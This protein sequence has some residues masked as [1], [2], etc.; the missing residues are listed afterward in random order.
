MFRE[1]VVMAS[2]RQADFVSEPF[3]WLA[4]L[5]VN[6]FALFIQNKEPNMNHQDAFT[7]YQ[8]IPYE[9]LI[10]NHI[11]H[12]LREVERL[13]TSD[14]QAQLWFLSTT[15][16]PFRSDPDRSNEDRNASTLECRNKSISLLTRYRT[17]RFEQF[18]VRLLRLL[19][20]NFERKRHLQPLAYVYSDHPSSNHDKG[21]ATLPL[22]E[23]I[24]TNGFRSSLEHPET[25]LHNHAVMVVAPGLIET[26]V[27][28]APDLDHTFTSLDPA[29]KSL[30]AVQIEPAMLRDV[31][32][33]SSKFM[34]HA[35]SRLNDTDLYT[36][37]P[38]GKSEPTFCRQKWERDE[39]AV[40][41]ARERE[42]QKRAARSKQADHAT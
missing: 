28:V 1:R 4:S 27:A 34:K 6:A 29:N 10:E 14:K 24:F 13:S 5:T 17:V 40:A 38:K 39:I 18:Y 22:E 3:G 15:Y 25:A 30:H 8:N 9:I 41:M 7:R 31:M 19:I 36:V 42:L 37:L 11:K 20:K 35:S 32:F 12:L 2:Q 21:Y 26:L 16:V 23:K 33:Y